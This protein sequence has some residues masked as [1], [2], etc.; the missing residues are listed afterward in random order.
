MGTK[1][2]QDTVISKNDVQYFNLHALVRVHMN[3][4]CSS[5][6]LI[7]FY[8]AYCLGEVLFSCFDAV[9]VRGREQTGEVPQAQITTQARVTGRG[10]T[11]AFLMLGPIFGNYARLTNMLVI[12]SVC[13]GK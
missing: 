1:Q 9:V 11:N 8:W 6:C 5:D 7:L 12:N 3:A 10:Q 4:T 13:F 2:R